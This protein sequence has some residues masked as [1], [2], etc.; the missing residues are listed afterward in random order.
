MKVEE[1]ISWQDKRINAMNKVIKK[2]GKP[3][4]LT[5]HFIDEYY[6]V[7]QSKARNKMEYKKGI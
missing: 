6:N 2:S 4:V 7:C 5:E 1:K 3:K